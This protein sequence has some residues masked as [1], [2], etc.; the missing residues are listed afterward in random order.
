MSEPRPLHAVLLGHGDMPAGMVDAVRHIT[1][2]GED[3]IVP[4][5]NR[6]KSP[7]TLAAEVVAAIGSGP[8]IV[9]TDLQS[10]S[11]GFVAR[12][13][14]LNAPELTVVSGVNLP[15]LVDFVMNRTLPLDELVPRLL[16]KGRAGM[17]CTPAELD[18][19]ERRA[20]SNR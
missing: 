19:H 5:S 13:L 16:S 20:V 3:V 8:A 12:R 17:G 15:L 11:C 1:G 18:E 7:D 4:V 9:F 14:R 10:G 6:G 2:C